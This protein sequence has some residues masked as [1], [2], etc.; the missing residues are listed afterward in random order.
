MKNIIKTRTLFGAGLTALAFSSI[1]TPTAFAQTCATVPTCDELGYD[2]SA[3]DCTGKKA[4]KC[5]FDNTKFYCLD[6]GETSGNN[7]GCT[8]PSV[9]YILYSDMSC[10]AD[11][12]SGKTAIGI[13]FEPDKRLAIALKTTTAYWSTTYF[14]VDT[15]SN[16]TSSSA[17]TGDWQGK[18]NTAKVV[19]YCNANDE[20]CPAF[21]YVKDYSTLGTNAGDWYLPSLGEL[22]EIYANKAALKTALTKANGRTL[23]ASSHWS[24]S[25]YSYGSAW[26]QDFS[27]GSIGSGGKTG[28]DSYVR[29]VLAF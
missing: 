12:V 25:E 14:D 3:S 4:L 5:P 16:I 29:P 8:S 26:L 6:G 21:D 15:L 11:V 22:N 20:S 24:S 2:L 13:I 9:G 27:K 1:F 19:A 7:G 28:N 10:S 17:V 18:S 23:P